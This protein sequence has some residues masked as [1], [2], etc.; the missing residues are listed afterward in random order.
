MIK[1]GILTTYFAPNYGA[2]LQ[3]FAL[4]KVLEEQ[5]Y[6]VELI[7][8]KQEAIYNNYKA[9]NK[10]KLIRKNFIKGIIYLIS[11]I[12]LYPI[13]K[14]RN[15]KFFNFMIK[16]LNPTPGFSNEIPSDKDIYLIGSDQ[17][18]NPNNTRGFDKV[19][20]GNFPTKKNAIIASYAASAGDIKYT[21]EEKAFLK[22]NIKNFHFVSVREESLRNNLMQITGR[23][24]IELSLDPTLLAN[25]SIYNEI[26][27]SNPLPNEKFVLFYYIR[28]CEEY[29]Q[30]IYEYAEQ[31]KC[32]L[33]VL[34]E[35]IITS[36]LSYSKKN[37]NM[38]YQPD[39][40]EETF[41]GA[42]KNAECIFTPSFHGAVFSIIYQKQF[43]SLILNDAN[44]DRVKN[45]LNNLRLS[46]RRIDL[47]T[48][49]KTDKNINFED[50]EKEINILRKESK[51]YINKVISAS[52][53]TKKRN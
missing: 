29:I 1:I 30:P 22:E 5:G 26:K 53:N 49:P 44:N 35:G 39:A 15:T 6:D 24:D 17:V 8:Y 2:M 14:R 40:G 11:L 52:N 21:D 47:N 48:F 38:I 18:W 19:Y 51:E 9:F 42:I 31:M 28:N 4:K 25:T 37:K 16:Y 33:L 10:R 13:L 41:I 34:S 12:R 7:R 45:L 43:Y 23:K 46:D 27:D 20:F 3:P 32:K 36:L 50:V